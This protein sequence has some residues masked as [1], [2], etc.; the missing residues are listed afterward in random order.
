MKLLIQK[1]KKASVKY[2]DKI[3]EIQEGVLAY[4]GIHKDDTEKDVEYLINKFLNLRFLED[5]NNKMNLSFKDKPFDILLISSF[6]LYADTK[7]GLR[8]S[9]NS[10]NNE[11]AIILYNI[12]VE[13]LS[14]LANIKTGKFKSHM[15]VFSINDGPINIEIESR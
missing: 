13:K 6:T 14:K 12:F 9:F 7:K 8:P 5:E 4:I 10:K 2:L 1:V 11:D 15:E 3:E